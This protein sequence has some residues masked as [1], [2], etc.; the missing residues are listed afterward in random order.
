[1]N[2]QELIVTVLLSVAAWYMLR[3]SYHIFDRTKE[4]HTGCDCSQK[5]L[6]KKESTKF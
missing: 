6:D 4:K 2:W 3:K 5:P 1:M